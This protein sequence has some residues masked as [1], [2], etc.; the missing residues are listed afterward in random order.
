MRSNFHSFQNAL[1]AGASPYAAAMQTFT[2]KIVLNGFRKA[3][4][5]TNTSTHV[6]VEFRRP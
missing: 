1:A 6:V 3:T 4:I 5:V 2:G